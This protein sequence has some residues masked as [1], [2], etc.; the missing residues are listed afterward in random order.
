MKHDLRHSHFETVLSKAQAAQI[1]D[2]SVAYLDRLYHQSDGP[3]PASEV[4]DGERKYLLTD[5]ETW[6]RMEE[7][8]QALRS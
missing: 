1:L 8:F 3:S 6:M 7:F 5:V 2:V 4:N